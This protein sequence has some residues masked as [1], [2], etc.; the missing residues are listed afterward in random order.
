MY[1]LEDII[2][3]LFKNLSISD[4]Y[5]LS[6]V[7]KI[8]YNIF[9]CHKLWKHYI[10]LIDFNILDAIKVKYCKSTCRKFFDLRKIIKLFLLD[11]DVLILYQN[12]ILDLRYKVIQ[13]IPCEIGQLVNLQRLDLSRNQ[14]QS[15]PSEIG[16]L[17]NLQW[18]DLSDNQITLIPAEISRLANLQWLDLSCNKIR[19]MPSEIGKLVNLQ[20]LYLSGNQITSLPAEIRE[21]LVNL[22][23]F[24][25]I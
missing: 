2:Y 18:L 10:K 9:E 12:I 24:T 20:E 25:D 16:Q 1:L 5:Q 13:S 14:I 19:S 23:I 3:E 4:A 15:I 21:L 8:F 6:T 17:V 7:N 22:N 11:E